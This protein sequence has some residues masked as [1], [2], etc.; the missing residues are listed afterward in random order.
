MRA[1]NYRELL[2]ELQDQIKDLKARLKQKW[3]PCSESLPEKFG[4]YIVTILL[5]NLG[6]VLTSF[7]HY[8][9]Q[10]GAFCGYGEII[11]W[12]PCPDPYNEIKLQ[13]ADGCLY[14][15]YSKECEHCAFKAVRK[16]EELNNGKI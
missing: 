6:T 2:Y 12:M 14:G 5:D 4:L 11:A 7:A 1:E 3:I 16:W 13:C 15:Q 8:D 10:K 9:P